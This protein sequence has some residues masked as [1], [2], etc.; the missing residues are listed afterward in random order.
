MKKL[1]LGFIFLAGTFAISNAQIERKQGNPQ[2]QEEHGQKPHPRMMMQIKQ[3]NLTESQKAQM[4]TIHEDFKKS[5]DELNKNESITLKDFRDKKEILHKQLKAKIEAILTPEQKQ[6]AEQ[7]KKEHQAEREKQADLRLEKMKTYL[8]LTDEQVAEI[9]ADR[10]E[11]QQ[12]IM[13][14]RENENLSRTEKKDQLDA[15][16][17][18]NKDGINKFLTP[19]QIKKMEEHKDF[20][21]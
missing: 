19:V 10:K 9:K 17:E 21:K 12:K 14:I 1:I 20:E 3:L 5:M 6:K 18:Q 8:G 4:K 7:L 15:L 11:F 16:H 13:S 2:Q